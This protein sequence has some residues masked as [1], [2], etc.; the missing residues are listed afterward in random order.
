MEEDTFYND[1]EIDVI[2]DDNIPSPV[3]RHE[4]DLTTVSNKRAYENIM[5]SNEHLDNPAKRLAVENGIALVSAICSASATQTYKEASVFFSGLQNTTPPERLLE[6]LKGFASD[7]Q[8]TTVTSLRDWIK[9]LLRSKDDRSRRLFGISEGNRFPDVQLAHTHEHRK[10][11]GLEIVKQINIWC[12]YDPITKTIWQK[13]LSL[14]TVRSG[15]FKKQRYVYEPF[16]VDKWK[17]QLAGIHIHLPTTEE[18]YLDEWVE[19]W[20]TKPVEARPATVDLFPKTIRNLFK[21]FNSKTRNAQKTYMTALKAHQSEIASGNQASVAPEAPKEL[22]AYS[23]HELAAVADVAGDY[24]EVAEYWLKSEDKRISE[25]VV[26][27]PSPHKI[28]T[29]GAFNIFDGLD[30]ERSLVVSHDPFP[31]QRMKRSLTMLLNH[32]LCVWFGGDV[33][34]FVFYLHAMAFHLQTREKPEICVII[35]GKEGCGKTGI[36][37]NFIRRIFGERYIG[38]SSRTSDLTEKFNGWWARLLVLV[39]EEAKMSAEKVD[40]LKHIVTALKMFHEPKGKERTKEESRQMIYVF[41]NEIGAKMV[42]G[43][44]SRRFLMSHASNHYFTLLGLQQN[45][46]SDYFNKLY[47]GRDPVKAEAVQYETALCFAK[48]LYEI[49]IGS[50]DSNKD[51][52]ENPTTWSLRLQT[53]KTEKPDQ[54]FWLTIISRDRYAVNN[55]V[56]K[57]FANPKEGEVPDEEDLYLHVEIIKT[58]LTEHLYGKDPVRRADETRVNTFL[59]EIEDVLTAVPKDRTRRTCNAAGHQIIY[60]GTLK[61]MREAFEKEIRGARWNWMSLEEKEALGPEAL[62]AKIA[63]E[64][65]ENN[66]PHEDWFVIKKG[67][68]KLKPIKETRQYIQNGAMWDMARQV[69][70]ADQFLSVQTTEAYMRDII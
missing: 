12:T 11:L 33:S 18:L 17:A 1:P 16:A 56:D 37:E 15:D 57:K 14:D 10:A 19:S 13:R 49:D 59:S 21:T 36:I 3:I 51:K 60:I 63:P 46:H 6:D 41:S 61:Q 26:W 69:M 44:E 2:E 53:L 25:N 47:G 5:T 48:L 7:V 70:G 4:I 65:L 45:D 32:L 24:V 9:Q 55:V 67:L 35:S 29:K 58:L 50:W 64:D 31:N 34:M 20:R 54:H 68:I 66:Y 52:P 23:S 30:M 42:V 8:Y 62:L 40:A 38:S 39:F 28:I 22:S 27:E 43:P